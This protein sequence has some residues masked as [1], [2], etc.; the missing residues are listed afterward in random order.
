MEIMRSVGLNAE[1]VFNSLEFVICFSVRTW[2][3]LHS[4][5]VS[6][7]CVFTPEKIQFAAR[8]MR[9]CHHPTSAV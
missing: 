7:F 3:N 8:M 4:F 5:P 9:Q 1:T 2:V 6:C